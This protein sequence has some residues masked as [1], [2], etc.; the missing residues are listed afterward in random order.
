MMSGRLLIKN[1]TGI[2]INILKAKKNKYKKPINN[3][4]KQI[5]KTNP[6]T[7]QTLKNKTKQI[8]KHKSKQI[9][10]THMKV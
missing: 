6:K 9:L 5:F 8:F 3:K 4:T 2:T 10:I 1:R 7:K